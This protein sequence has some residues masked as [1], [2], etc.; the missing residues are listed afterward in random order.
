MDREG[1]PAINGELAM[2]FVNS[3]LPDLILLDIKMPGLDGY[4]V[5][6][7]LKA[8]DNTRQ[9]PIIFLSALEDESD[10]VKGFLAGGVDYITKPFQPEELLARVGVHLRL[11]ELTKGLE[12]EVSA[13]TLKLRIA[14]K[15]LEEEINRRQE[16]EEALRE[17]RLRLGNI[18]FNSPGAIYRCANDEYW[19]MEFVSAAI[20]Q[21][22]GYAS[23]ELLHNQVR[24]F[25]SIIHAD[26]QK[27]V[28]NAVTTALTNKDRYQ[29]DFRLMAADGTQRWVHDQGLG[30]FGSDGK[31]LYLDG[32]I[33][34]ITAQRKA[35]EMLKL[36]AERME[37]LLQL[38]QMSDASQDELMRFTYEAAVRLT[39]S[40]LGYL[41]LMNDDE[42]TLNV[43][44]W[45]PEA[46]AGCDVEGTPQIFPLEGSGLWGEAIRQR[47][48]I[49]TNDYIAPNP[50]K[51][52][53]PEGHVKL[54]RHMNLPVIVD[55]KIVLVAGVGNKEEDYNEGD[56]QQLRLLMEGMWRLIEPMCT[57]QG[58]SVVR[59]S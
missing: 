20:T 29:V 24:S 30:V 11:Q 56:V 40:K 54:I 12:Q 58:D 14:N 43:K 47:R 33:V 49:I 1:L 39:H 31:L 44:Y 10:K 38:Y 37:T 15:H 18:V 2:E 28:T 52:G 27:R 36:N 57:E 21:I 42:T 34:D 55:D 48:P 26:D 51:K 19:T 35:E 5:C 22:S 9:I 23:E 25:A 46:M 8:D 4:E 45:S 7:R 3:R 59:H 16:V 6:R 13:R 50:W 41:G 32:I 17:S 53:T